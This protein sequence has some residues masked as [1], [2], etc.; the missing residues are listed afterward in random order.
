MGGAGDWAPQYP[1]IPNTG[2]MGA[3]LG[4][5]NRRYNM[6]EVGPGGWHGDRQHLS[7]ASRVFLTTPP[8]L[9]GKDPGMQWVSLGGGRAS[10]L[11]PA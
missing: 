6:E 2:M 5:Q 11:S 10:F 4:Q 8:D 7:L 1:G 3:R 9:W